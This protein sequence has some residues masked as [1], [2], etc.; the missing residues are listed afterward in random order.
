M[1]PRGHLKEM[2]KQAIMAT[3]R[4]AGRA[5]RA[6]ERRDSIR[7]RR[8][9]NDKNARARRSC[10]PSST[11]QIRVLRKQR[12]RRAVRLKE[13]DVREFSKFHSSRTIRATVTPRGD[14][15][16]PA[17]PFT[18]T[19]EG[20]RGGVGRWGRRGGPF[21]TRPTS[22]GLIAPDSSS[23]RQPKDPSSYSSI[24]DIRR[25]LEISR[26]MAPFSLTK[27]IQW[28]GDSINAG[29]SR[30]LLFS[31]YSWVLGLDQPLSWSKSGETPEEELAAL[32]AVAERLEAGGADISQLEVILL[33]PRQSVLKLVRRCPALERLSGGDLMIRMMDL[34][35]LFPENNVARMI[36][37]VPGG[38]LSQDWA[39]TKARLEGVYCV[40]RIEYRPLDH[41]LTRSL[42]RSL[43]RSP[44]EASSILRDGLEG[45][46]VDAIFEEDPTI[47]FEDPESLRYGIQQMEELWGI[48]EAILKNSWPDELALAVRALGY[49][50]APDSIDKIGAE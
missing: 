23:R 15:D 7:V 49:K 50:G 37:L 1:V 31:A 9:Q 44:T 36:E 13:D 17:M 6:K 3:F 14:R 33:L 18:T 10:C 21:T 11:L 42:T 16:R 41:S 20:T 35:L 39:V 8:T 30:S 4:R 46:D 27:A 32:D 5:G 38:F 26:G 2:S 34:K 22:R 25:E 43:A 29:G 47:L 19:L 48:D 24:E 12:G 45:A 40:L 28:I